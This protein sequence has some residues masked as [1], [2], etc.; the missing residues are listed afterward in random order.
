MTRKLRIGS[1]K[2]QL[3]LRQSEWVKQMLEARGGYCCTIVTIETRGDQILDLPL[4]EIGDKGLFTR[5]LEHGLLAGELD[6]AVHSL[7][8][9]PTE[10]P[11][12]LALGA[13][14]RREDPRDALVSGQGYTLATLPPRAIVATGSLRRKV[15]LLRLRPDLEVPA[16]RG[17]VPTRLRKMEEKGYQA[18][19]LAR[20]G[21]ERLGLSALAEP[22]SP[23][24]MIPAA[25]QGSLG[26]ECRRGE[27]SGVLEVLNDGA[28]ALECRSERAVLHLLGGTCQIPMGVNAAVT[29][30]RMRIVAFVSDR[31]GRRFIK[32]RIEGESDYAE[33]LAAELA[34]RL[35]A[36]GA[37]ELVSQAKE[38][39][40]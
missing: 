21:L 17:N 14:T 40:N 15:Q 1:R 27:L 38:G 30:D 25:G 23:E 24:Q 4:P 36:Q 11:D 9:L 10:L 32:E 26:I 34:R 7:K 35:L 20:A 3:A 18:I 33:D 37:G 12:G 29:G 28:A 16:I 39:G 31:E 8:D 2:S 13:V 19:I 22:I 5:E 6:L